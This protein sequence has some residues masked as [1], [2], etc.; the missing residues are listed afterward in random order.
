MAIRPIPGG[1]RT[2]TTYSGATIREASVRDS[3]EGAY[4]RLFW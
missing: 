2:S 1:S 3:K 4:V